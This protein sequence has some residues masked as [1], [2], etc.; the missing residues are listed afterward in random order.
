M[1]PE[2][3]KP[4]MGACFKNYDPFVP[5]CEQCLMKPKCMDATMDVELKE[6]LENSSE[7]R[8]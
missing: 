2:T 8:V 4:T 3:E 6:L 5:E 7:D 1:R